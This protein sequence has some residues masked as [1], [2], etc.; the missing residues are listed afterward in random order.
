MVDGLGRSFF[1]VDVVIYDGTNHAA[2]VDAMEF[3]IGD[4][5]VC[6]PDRPIVMRLS[7]LDAIRQEAKRSDG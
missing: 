4:G 2:I 6:M 1:G 5:I 3:R 7:E